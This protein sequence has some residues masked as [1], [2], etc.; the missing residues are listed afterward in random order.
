MEK[1]HRINR[2]DLG[3]PIWLTL[4]PPS[5]PTAFSG[6]RAGPEVIIAD[7]SLLPVVTAG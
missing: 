4:R 3:L 6:T 1:S 7:A 5:R 2:S